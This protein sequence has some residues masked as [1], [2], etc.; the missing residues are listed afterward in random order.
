MLTE[1]IDA[2]LK[3]A[4]KNRDTTRMSVLRLLKTAIN[5]RMIEKNVN[6]LKDDGVIALIR[7]DIKR[8]QDSIEQ[9]RKG[10]REDLAKKEEAELE[11]LK[12]YLPKEASP[13]EIKEAVKKII[14]EIRAGGKKDFGKVMKAA[15][16]KF[17][18]ACDGKTLSSI[19]NELL[20]GPGQAQ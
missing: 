20:S 11:I 15:M 18:G 19:V 13:E 4:I 9:F 7:K 8:H 10:N 16:E 5:N 1:K 17:K 6:E 14:E 2:D 12:S 3:A